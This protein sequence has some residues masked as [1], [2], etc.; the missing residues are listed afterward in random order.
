MKQTKIQHE[1][2]Y[3]MVEAQKLAGVPCPNCAEV[4]SLFR[5]GNY[6]GCRSCMTYFGEE[7]FK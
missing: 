4:M 3:F 1:S 2:E 7:N 6:I 5:G